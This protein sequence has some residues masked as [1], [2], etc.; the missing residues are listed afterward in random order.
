MR[1]LTIAALQR[2]GY[3]SKPQERGGVSPPTLLLRALSKNT[4]ISLEVFGF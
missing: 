3:L 2:F 1:N 4:E